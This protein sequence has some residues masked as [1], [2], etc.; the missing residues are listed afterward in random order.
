[1][2]ET[3]DQGQGMNRDD[4]LSALF[5]NMVAQQTQTAFMFLG[6]MPHPETGETIQDLET[7]EFLINQLEMLEVKTKGNLN[8]DEENLLKRSLAGLRMAF[9]EAVNRG[10][11]H[12]PASPPKTGA[13]A[14]PAQ[15][16]PAAPSAPTAPS[17]TASGAKTEEAPSMAK[18]ASRDDESRKK[19][20]K[21]Y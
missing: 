17:A 5:A 8:K 11:P 2:N 14:A 7:A 3:Q 20:S 13:P 9:V 15:P 4:L 12:E 18:D 19:F 1:M 16:T 10:E 6:R 21:K